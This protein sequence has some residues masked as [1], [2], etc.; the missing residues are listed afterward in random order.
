M[1]IIKTLH[2]RNNYSLSMD[3]LFRQEVREV[4]KKHVVQFSVNK[5][6]EAKPGDA[7]ATRALS[8]CKLYQGCC[9]VTPW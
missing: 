2:I 1:I 9:S 5:S 4:I 7:T 6:D 3:Y 8:E